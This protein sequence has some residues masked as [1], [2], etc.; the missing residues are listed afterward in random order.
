MGSHQ[1]HSHGS[2]TCRNTGY[3]K[4]FC[5]VLRLLEHFKSDLNITP[6]RFYEVEEQVRSITSVGL[7]KISQKSD[8]V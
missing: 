6:K 8:S 1:G 3:T 2:S 5:V 7:A 4:Y